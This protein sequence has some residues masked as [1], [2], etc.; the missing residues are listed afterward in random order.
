M[1]A[2][3]KTLFRQGSCAQCH[4]QNGTGGAFGPPLNDSIYLHNSGSFEETIDIITTGVPADKLLS[5][6]SFV[7]FPMF[8][9]GNMLLTDAQLRSVAAYVWT[10]SHPQG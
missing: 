4:G 8:P 7:N 1:V 3:G 6:S 5:P 10:L 2:E 9:R